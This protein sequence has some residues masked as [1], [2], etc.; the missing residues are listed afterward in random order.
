MNIKQLIAY[1][2]DSILVFDKPFGMLAQKDK[3]NEDG[4]Y[5]LIKSYLKGTDFL[6]MMQRIDRVAGGLM[7]FAKTPVAAKKLQQLFENRE[8]EK[9][10]LAI[11]CQQ[12]EPCEGVLEH[13]LKKTA[14]SNSVRAFNK[15]IAYSKKAILHYK[16][17]ANGKSNC[18]L[19]VQ[20]TTGRLHQ[21]RV[22][23]ASIGCTVLGDKKYGKTSFLADK[24]I[25]LLS[26][27]LKFKHP[28][29]GKQMNIEAKFPTADY[30]QE[31]SSYK[32]MK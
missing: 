19:Q 5:E 15:K 13:Y 3:A 28:K 18:L 23:L 20:P 8:V 4:A 1:E 22:Q 14:N 17:L 11:V 12:P 24:S 6:A 10:Y 16:L 9:S 26:H 27:N 2:D 32:L 25:A 21:I 29:S 31:F 7:L 30:W